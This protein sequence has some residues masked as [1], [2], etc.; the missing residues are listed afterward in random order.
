M[1]TNPQGNAQPTYSITPAILLTMTAVT[2]MVDAV[3][4]LALGRVF[5]A[6]MTGNV[7]LL[8][9]AVG[10]TPGLSTERSLLALTFFLIGAVL[11]GRIGVTHAW[12]GLLF[13]A[14]LLGFAGLLA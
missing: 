12:G 10:R 5:T 14:G 11:G 9:F 2:G 3:S 4:F 13:E 8:G 7:M 1:S 6:N